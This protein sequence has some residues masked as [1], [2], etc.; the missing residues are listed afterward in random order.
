[1]ADLRNVTIVV[2]VLEETMKREKKAERQTVTYT[3]VLSSISFI[4][5]T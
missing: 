2:S 4:I 1:M 5:T 3:D